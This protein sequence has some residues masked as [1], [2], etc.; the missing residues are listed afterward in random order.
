MRRCDGVIDCWNGF[1]ELNCSKCLTSFSCK[2]ADGIFLKCIPG[3]KLC[4]GKADCPD[5]SDESLYCH[6]KYLSIISIFCLYIQEMAR[7]LPVNFNVET[8]PTNVSQNLLDVM[9]I[10][11]VKTYYS[12]HLFGVVNVRII[13][14]TVQERLFS[15]INVCLSA[16][17][18]IISPIVKTIEMNRLD[19][20]NLPI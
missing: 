5:L 19:Y 14:V 2:A 12:D 3:N 6:R 11:I 4:D 8:N 16:K 15:M 1:D 20:L 9:G 10:P 17:C 13:L 7:V 18:A